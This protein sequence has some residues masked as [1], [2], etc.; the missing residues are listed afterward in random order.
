MSTGLTKAQMAAIHKLTLEENASRAEALTSACDL[1]LALQG[2]LQAAMIDDPKIGNL[3]EDANGPL[4]TFAVA[5]SRKSV[6]VGG[7]GYPIEPVGY[8]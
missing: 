4:F 7:R 8:S 2:L 3:F 1:Q 5:C 6:P